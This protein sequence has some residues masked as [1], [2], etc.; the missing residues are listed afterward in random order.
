M[1]S[2]CA[3]M[4][5]GNGRQKLLK[6]RVFDALI[7]GYDRKVRIPSYCRNLIRRIGDGFGFYVNL[8]PVCFEHPFLP[9]H[10]AI[11]V[12]YECEMKRYLESRVSFLSLENSS[13]AQELIYMVG[14]KR[15]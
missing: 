11:Y 13:K 12:T 3:G 6:G 8:A 15:N 9:D 14:T 7:T 2:Q 4:S 10:D 1:T 5:F